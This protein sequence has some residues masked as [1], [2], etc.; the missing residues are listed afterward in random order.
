ME[1][2]ISIYVF[3]FPR[4]VVD[5]L[6]SILDDLS[7]LFILSII[8]STYNN[9]FNVFVIIAKVVSSKHAVKSKLI[10]VVIAVSTGCVVAVSTGCVTGAPFT[11]T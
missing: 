5:I 3:I 10:I 2:T 1:L 6:V 8:F 4:V 9:G 7:L 11:R